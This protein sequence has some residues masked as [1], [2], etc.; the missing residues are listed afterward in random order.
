MKRKN[1]KSLKAY[2]T[3]LSLPILILPAF[4]L[5]SCSTISQYIMPINT[6]NHYA[7]ANALQDD[8]YLKHGKIEDNGIQKD[9]TNTKFNL[10]NDYIVTNAFNNSFTPSITG[11]YAY[12]NS[13]KMKYVYSSDNNYYW[14]YKQADF[15]NK[16]WL[17]NS[18]LSISD[19]NN[20][21]TS[22]SNLMNYLN[23]SAVNKISYN[24]VNL[25]NLLNNYEAR[26][27]STING[28]SYLDG[29][30]RLGVMIGN[31]A[32]LTNNNYAP[33]AFNL[34]SYDKTNDVRNN[35]FSYL[36]S[37]VNVLSQNNT[38][39]KFGPYQV[40][41][42]ES[43]VNN[44]LYNGSSIASSDKIYPMMGLNSEKSI[45]DRSKYVPENE[46]QPAAYYT[47]DLFSGTYIYSQENKNFD[48]THGTLSK[49]VHI[50]TTKD[51]QGNV[52]ETGI[53]S[54]YDM[55]VLINLP[56]NA[57][58]YG[59]YN[60]SNNHNNSIFINDWKFNNNE[61]DNIHS[62]INYTNAWSSIYD[63]KLPNG[64]QPLKSTEFST[65]TA[66]NGNFET[67][68]K[69]TSTSAS[70]WTNGNDIK[71]PTISKWINDG[72]INYSSFI[73]LAKYQMLTYTKDIKLKDKTQGDNG[74]LHVKYEV[75]IFAG[76]EDVVIPS[77][78]AFDKDNYSIQNEGKTDEIW[79]FDVSKLQNK[80]TAIST[81]L[82][83]NELPNR[84]STWYKNAYD[85]Y[86]NNKYFLYMWL[87]ALNDGNSVN[88]KDADKNVSVNNVA[89]IIKTVI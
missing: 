43:A 22:L 83:S 60:P 86:K 73:A 32:N 52:K 2:W 23:N 51:S 53:D 69:I 34:G 58:Q 71:E 15:D 28:N 1:H 57:I 54:I 39:Y 7:N 3:L 20:E 11:S 38:K 4:T 66:Y 33:E 41:W 56:N 70:E 36:Y 30:K 84:T 24:F 89:N 88:W 42:N 16:Q 59:F 5:T 46:N 77:Y 27:V 18:S 9:I 45:F 55:P 79:F 74:V 48:W 31:N 80:I 40:N 17:T 6:T 67:K 68:D 50:A 64:A 85:N 87:Y 47:N 49:Y 75:P 62:T 61:L 37:Q 13:L 25:F 35:Y 72:I 8:Y 76:Y 82:N 21:L 63:H 10:A 12:I 44:E 29:Y 26:L 19:K 78:L 65:S 14:G 81:T